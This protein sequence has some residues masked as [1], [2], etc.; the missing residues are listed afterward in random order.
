MH[1]ESHGTQSVTASVDT[2]RLDEVI[3]V[4][5]RAGIVSMQAHPPTLEELFMRHYGDEA[6]ADDATEDGR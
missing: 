4:L 5:H 3:G 6:P 2:D 1:D